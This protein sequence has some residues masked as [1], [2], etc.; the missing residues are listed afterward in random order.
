MNSLRAGMAYFLWVFAAGFALGVVREFWL[1]PWVGARSAELAEVPLMLL[2]VVLAARWS[3][4][5]FDLPPTAGLGAGALAVG[6]LLLAEVVLV[7]GLR[8][9]SLGDYLANRDPVA[10]TVYA[11]S[12]LLMA[13][14]PWLLARAGRR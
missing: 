5:R 2:V 8:G 10:G 4:R 13:V 9:M 7:L 14:M 11:V 12:L 3:V 1:S 6:W